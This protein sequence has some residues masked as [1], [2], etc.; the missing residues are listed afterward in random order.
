MCLV[1]RECPACLFERGSQS[2]AAA[3]IQAG[4]PPVP[5]WVRTDRQIADA[6]HG[7]LGVKGAN[8]DGDLGS[9]CRHDQPHGCSQCSC[10]SGSRTVRTLHTGTHINQD[11]PGLTGFGRLGQACF[12]EAVSP[13]KRALN[14]EI[15]AAVMWAPTG[16]DLWWAK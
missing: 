5:Q 16:V 6:Y 8:A 4:E 3:V 1:V 13:T 10:H 11:K 7:W 15:S 9:L 2:C 12:K 14:I